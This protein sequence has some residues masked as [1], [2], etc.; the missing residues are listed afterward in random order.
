MFI[1]IIECSKENDT[2]LHAQL[3][4]EDLTRVSLLQILL[5]ISYI[6]SL[7]VCVFCTQDEMVSQL[8][9]PP[10][11]LLAFAGVHQEMPGQAAR[12]SKGAVGLREAGASVSSIQLPH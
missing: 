8:P 9:A 11:V 7:G 6:S 2:F 10:A 3:I 12:A 1:D 4:L 5:L